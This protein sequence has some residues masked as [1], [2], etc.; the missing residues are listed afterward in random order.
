MSVAKPLAVTKQGTNLSGSDARRLVTAVFVAWM[1][2]G[3]AVIWLGTALYFDY[4]LMSLT[5]IAVGFGG[6]GCI[7]FA[8]LRRPTLAK[9]T[10]LALSNIGIFAGSIVVH[11]SANVPYIFATFIGAPFLYFSLQKEA[12]IVIFFAATAILTGSIL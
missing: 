1:V 12:R 8:K 3:T 10:L 5:S 6:V 11:P 2:V 9:S 4:V 7:V